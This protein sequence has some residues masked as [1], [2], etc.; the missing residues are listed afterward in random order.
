MELMF[1]RLTQLVGP[2]DGHLTVGGLSAGCIDLVEA[3][4][5]VPPKMVLAPAG[6]YCMD[7]RGSLL[8]AAR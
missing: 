7:G 6:R 3:G 2:P 1:G 4:G 5:P 8:P